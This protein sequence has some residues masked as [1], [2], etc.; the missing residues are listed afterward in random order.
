MSA[1]MG[2]YIIIITK[3]KRKQDE[4]DFIAGCQRNR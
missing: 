3:E 4:S 1:G 2:D